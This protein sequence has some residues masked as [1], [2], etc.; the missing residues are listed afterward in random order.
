VDAEAKLLLE[1]PT[2]DSTR[3]N[4]ELSW[5]LLQA[6]PQS[7]RFK[8]SQLSKVFKLSCDSLNCSNILFLSLSPDFR[9][10]KM[11]E[12]NCRNPSHFEG[13][14][15]YSVETFV[16]AHSKSCIGGNGYI[17]IHDQNSFEF[18]FIYHLRL[19]KKETFIVEPK[20]TRTDESLRSLDPEK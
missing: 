19:G 4:F 8:S 7:K 12:V 3:T 18:V 14:R 9:A 6:Q 2:K 11:T 5:G 10:N 1:K 13:S 15:T 20:I 16:S 17:I